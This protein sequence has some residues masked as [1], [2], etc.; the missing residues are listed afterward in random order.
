MISGLVIEDSF[1]QR[2][3]ELGFCFGKKN[4]PVQKTEKDFHAMLIHCGISR[5]DFGPEE[6]RLIL[7]I[8]LRRFCFILFFF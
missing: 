2:L 3:V 1:K 7:T 5:R 8:L 6:A 4:I